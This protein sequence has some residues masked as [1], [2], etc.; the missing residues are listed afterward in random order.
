VLVKDES[1]RFGMGAFKI[2]GV[3]YAI[4]ALLD[5]RIGRP[6]GAVR[7]L[8]CATEGNHG[9]AVAR[10]ASERGLA[11]VV[12]M[13]S[14]AA[15]ARIEA[16][17]QE[18]ADVILVDGTYD[19][20]VRRMAEEA[21]RLAGAVIVSDTAWPGYEEIP[22]AIMAGYTWLMAEAASQWAR[23]PDIVVVQAGVGGLAA[24]V[25]SWLCAR[26]EGRSFVIC[27]EPVAAACVYE[28]IAAGH[29][30]TIVPGPTE[31]AG[32]R[33]G[34]VSSIAFPVLSRAVGA[35]AA[36]DDE[37]VREMMRRLSAPA[38]ADP[39][40]GAGPSGA[41]GLAALVR[42]MT[43]PDYAESRRE[44]KVTPESTSFAVNTEAAQP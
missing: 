14:S 10:V 6:G 2:A 42:W 24:A 29:R 19:D 4:D 11:A 38:G 9:R 8:V 21:R 12:Y 44:A 33:C 35:C 34:E 20:A 37:D 5:G 28:S 41:C 18:G 15:A 3:L 32:L 1:K 17:R 40:I 30:R 43:S 22:R 27:A 16:I 25:A 13:R 7:T 36:L 39:S 26:A 23:L 31:M